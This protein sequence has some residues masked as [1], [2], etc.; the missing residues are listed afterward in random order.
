[1][2]RR[3]KIESIHG[4]YELELEKILQRH[5]SLNDPIMSLASIPEGNGRFALGEIVKNHFVQK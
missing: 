2:T 1:M 5:T 4:K 3:K